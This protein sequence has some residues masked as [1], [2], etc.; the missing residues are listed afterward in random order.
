MIQMPRE[1]LSPAESSLAEDIMK[2]IR[3]LVRG[4]TVCGSRQE[5]YADPVNTRYVF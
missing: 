5:Q 3:E 1:R 4:T 2:C